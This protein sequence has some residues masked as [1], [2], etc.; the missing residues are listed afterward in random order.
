M[1]L[2][3]NLEKPTLNIENISDRTNQVEEISAYILNEKKIFDADKAVSG[4]IIFDEYKK[5]FDE[6]STFPEIPKSTF[7]MYISKVSNLT[8]SR[9]NCE[10]RKKGYYFDRILEKIEESIKTN[11]S[12][13]KKIEQEEIIERKEAKEKG[14]LLEKDLYPFFEQWLFQV[15]NERIADISNNRS[16]GKWAN[17]DLIGIKI[18]NLFGATEIEITTIEAKI[19]IDHWEQWIFESVAHTIFSNRSYFAFVHSENHINKITPDLKHYAET[20]KVGI[21]II[22]VEP[23][24]YLKI[25]KKERFELTD[26][27]HK[28]IE[29]FPAPF[30]DPHMK[31][32]KRFLKGLN[33]DEPKDLY[34][35]GKTLEK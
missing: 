12:E 6:N 1:T 9:I 14:Y 3:M 33:I 2:I 27:N 18:N 31:F 25:Q 22:A 24:D 19:T 8:N 32:K 35:F 7:L 13:Q 23:N 30:N 21:L 11:E 29:Y 5:L 20:F 16:Q 15:D 26:E 4:S 10:G 34:S 17:P 28:M